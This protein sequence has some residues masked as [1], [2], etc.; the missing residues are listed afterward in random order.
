MRLVQDSAAAGRGRASLVGDPIAFTA[1]DIEQPDSCTVL[2]LHPT[3]DDRGDGRFNREYARDPQ[4]YVELYRVAVV[5]YGPCSRVRFDPRMFGEAFVLLAEYG[6]EAE[7][8][9]RVLLE[10]R[11]AAEQRCFAVE[12]RVDA[13]E[14]AAALP[15]VD[16]GGVTTTSA[17]PIE[18]LHAAV[19]LVVPK[20]MSGSKHSLAGDGGD[21]RR[22]RD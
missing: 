7:T 2:S 20:R 11:L 19:A 10:C 13:S 3:F 1:L 14:A 21:G 8:A 12:A 5:I 17:N 6:G 15:V 9:R 4:A 18:A 22:K 16:V